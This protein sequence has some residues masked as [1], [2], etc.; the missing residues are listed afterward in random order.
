[1]TFTIVKNPK[2]WW[3]VIVPGV[4]DEG[5]PV[6]NQFEMRFKLLDDAQSVA[7]QDTILAG[8]G[9]GG[10][11]SLADVQ[12]KNIAAVMRIAEDWRGVEMECGKDQAAASVPFSAEN[13][14]MLCNLPN[15][16]DAIFRA[17]QAC[18]AGEPEIR[19]G[20]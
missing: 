20:N 7:L 9:S 16:S 2:A 1:M 8:L 6:S 3:P 18:R 15:V 14:W 11:G 10:I 19:R 17:Y 13:V 12:Q 4:T 5:K